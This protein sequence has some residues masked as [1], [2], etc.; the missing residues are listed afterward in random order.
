M[1]VGD[2]VKKKCGPR[3]V[4]D[5]ETLALAIQVVRTGHIS[6]WAASLKYG[7]PKSTLADKVCGNTSTQRKGPHLFWVETLKTVLLHGLLRWLISGMDRHMIRSSA[8][9][10]ILLHD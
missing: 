7:I 10:K 8:R 4:H 6:I 1:M 2:P 9:F 5:E 3:K